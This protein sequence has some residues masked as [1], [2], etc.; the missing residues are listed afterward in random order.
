MD[1]FL[2][3]NGLSL[4]R[5]KVVKLGRSSHETIKSLNEEVRFSDASAKAFIFKPR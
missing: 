1:W 5:V 4:E 3:D 2:Y